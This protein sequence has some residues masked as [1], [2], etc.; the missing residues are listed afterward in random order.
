MTV[1]TMIPRM[2]GNESSLCRISARS[3]AAAGE[4]GEGVVG[5]G[6]VAVTVVVIVAVADDVVVVGLTVGEEVV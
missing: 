5:G 3:D 1:E 2:L 6:A 4:S